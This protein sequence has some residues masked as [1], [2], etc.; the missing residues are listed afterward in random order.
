LLGREREG[1]EQSPAAE[2]E[3]HDGPAGAQAIAGVV[4]KRWSWLKHL[5]ADGAYD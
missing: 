1:R 4:R 3:R 5:F 2:G